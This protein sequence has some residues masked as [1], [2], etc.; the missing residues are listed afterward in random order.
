VVLHDRSGG[1][2]DD[3][4]ASWEPDALIGLGVTG[5]WA[6]EVSDNAS[7]DTGR[8]RSWS[9]ALIVGGE[10]TPEVCD[11]GVD[12][13]ANGQADCA[14]DACVDAPACEGL[15]TITASSDEVVAIPDNDSDGDYGLI[16]VVDTGEIV[17]LAVDVDITHPTRSDLQLTLVHES[18]ASV[19][20]FDQEGGN[21]DDLVR[22]FETEVFD[23]LEAAGLWSLEVRDLRNLDAGT[24]N[25]WGLEMT[26]R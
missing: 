2:E 11:D 13:D 9:L 10:T 25:Q 12:N 24:L 1:G 15:D 4:V 20:L 17:D 19:I 26:V 23:G 5:T 8:L 7:A 3:L 21:E 22:R 16:E 14:D 18:G 6:L